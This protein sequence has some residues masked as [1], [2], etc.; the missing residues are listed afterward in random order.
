MTRFHFTIAVCAVLGAYLILVLWKKPV[1]GTGK[2]A[3]KLS[4]VNL[5]SWILFLPLNPL[6]HPPPQLMFGLVLWLINTPLL[7][8]LIV[9][10]WKCLNDPDENKVFLTAVT[11]LVAFNIIMMWI[12]PAVEL[13]LES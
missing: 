1:S 7:I 8:A 12:I 10:M 3:L 9:A 4:L 11:T 2:F 13:F 5:V 6:G